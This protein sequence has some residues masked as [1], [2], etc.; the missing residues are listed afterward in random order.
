MRYSVVIRYIGMVLLVLAA[1]M[2]ASAGISYLSGVDSAYTPLVMSSLLTLLMGCFPLIFVPRTDR[3]SQKEA[4][5]IVVGAWVV[6][7]IVGM[8]PYLMW[9]GEFTP[10]NAW[11]ESVSGFTTTGAS[12]LND[13]EALPR[14][15]LFWRMSTSWIGGIGVVMFALVIL[16]SIGKSK[17]M[18]SHFE[19]SSLAKDNFN[20]YRTPTVVRIILSVYIGLTIASTLILKLCGMN[21]FDALCHAMSACGTCGFSTKNLSIGW[22]NSPLIEMVLVVIMAVAGIHFGLIFATLTRKKNNIFRSEITRAYF[23]VIAVSALLIGISI[24]AA[25]VYPSLWTSLRSAL[26]H[27][28]SLITTT[29][30]A[31]ADCNTWTS[32]AML[33]LIFCSIVCACAGS[34]SGGLKMDRL[35]LAIKMLRN[36]L[37]SQQHPNAIIRTKVDGI[38]QDKEMLNGVMVYIVAY[39]LLIL[40][41]AFINTML[42]ADIMTGFSA[43]VSCV[44][45]VGP[46]FGEVGTMDNYSFM[47]AVMKF[48]L[49]ALMLFGRLEIFGL[50]QLFFIRWWR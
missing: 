25:D 43:S 46:G 45:N 11:F 26:F 27:T 37:R 48:N 30:F 44:S 42:G 32:F 8:F 3:I 4:Y 35:W 9:G 24:W 41:G 50:I 12:I 40:A 22:F 17:M 13:I 29:G 21:W 49:T 10:I 14:G 18:L 20:L 16:P 1:F 47:P 31:T 23:S 33:I 38:P 5:C 2:L 7:S 6:A 34:T 28:V 15:L 39:M 36:R 19:L